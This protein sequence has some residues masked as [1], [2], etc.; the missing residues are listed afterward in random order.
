MLELESTGFVFR[1][2]DSILVAVNRLGT[3]VGTFTLTGDELNVATAVGI[4]GRV[5][6]DIT[7][8]ATWGW[9]DLIAANTSLVVTFTK[10]S[11]GSAPTIGIDRLGF[12]VTSVASPSRS[13]SVYWSDLNDSVVNVTP[14]S[15]SPLEVLLRSLAHPITAIA[16]D[17]INNKVY[18]SY[19]V[20]SNSG[21]IVRCD[22]D[23]TNLTTILTDSKN[24]T[25]LDI[26]PNGGYVYWANVAAIKR[27]LVS[28][29][30]TPTIVTLPA[31][32]SSA[33][34]VALDVVGGKVYWIQANG[35]K[36]VIQYSNLD[37]SSMATLVND[38]FGFGSGN[39]NPQDIELDLTA[40]KMYFT[41]ARGSGT[42]F[43]GVVNLDGTNPQ[44]LFSA[45][46]D[47]PTGLGL[48]VANGIL[49]WADNTGFWKGTTAGTNK[50]KMFGLTT[51]HEV[52]VPNFSVDTV[53]T[54]DGIRSLDPVPLTDTYDS[55]KLQFVSASIA[56]DSNVGGVLTWNNIG[57]INAQMSK[58]ITV[59]FKAVQLAGNATA[60]NVSNTAAVTAAKVADGDPA[61]TATST[62]LVDITATAKI[63]DF[64]WDDK[65]G[66]GTFNTGD[67][68]LPGVGVQLWNSTG[69]TM[70]QS[71]TTDASGSYLFNAVAGTYIV[72][73]DTTTL[74]TGY[75]ATY[76]ADGTGTANQSTVT[77]A[78]AANP[79]DNLN[80]DVG[81]RF[82][83]A[84]V[85]G[86]VWKD[87]NADG[88]RA[89]TDSGLG[90]VTVELRNSGGTVVYTTTTASDG[91]YWFRG[92]TAGSYYL[93]VLPATLP[94]GVGTWT[95]TADPD[96]T[97]D[98]RT[99]SPSGTFALVAGDIKGAYDFGYALAGT[100]SIG[101]QVFYDWNR[102]NVMDPGDEGIPNVTVNLY[103]DVNYN[104]VYDVG[105]DPLVQTTSTNSGGIYGFSNLPAGRFFVQVDQTDPDFLANVSP[106]TTNPA[107]ILLYAGEVRTDADFGYCP[108]G[109]GS[110]SGIVWHD[111]NMDQA[112]GGAAT[113]E[114]GLAGITVS[115]QVDLNNDGTWVTLQTATTDSGGNYSFSSL[116]LLTYRVVVSPTDP[117]LPK[118]S[119][120]T[121]WEN[122]T[123]TTLTRT[124]TSGSPTATANFGFANWPAIGDFV[125]YDVNANGTQDANETGIPNVTL[126]LYTDPNGDGTGGALVATTTTSAGGANP[127]GFYQFTHVPPNLKYRVVVDTTTLPTKNGSPIP[128]TSDPNRD[129]VPP[130]WT[131]GTPPFDNMDTN[132]QLGVADYN[133]ADFG[134]QPPGSIGDRVW[135]DQNGNGVQDSGEPGIAG[136][137]VTAT[138]GATTYTT[139]T[140]ADG[141]YSFGNLADGTWTVWISGTP[142]SGLTPTY[143]ADGGVL[144][145]TSV[146]INLGD[147]TNTFGAMGVDFGLM[148]SGSYS[149]SGTVVSNDAPVLGLV[150]VPA[151]EMP[152]LGET[153]YLYTQSGTFLGSTT[154]NIAGQYSF[155]HLPNGTYKV[156]L[157]TGSRP[158]EWAILDTVTGQTPAGSVLDNGSSV[159]QSNIPIAGASVTRVDFAFQRSASLD[160]GDLP[161]SYG[162]TTFNENG[163]WHIIPSGGA[164]VYLGTVKPDADPD[165]RPSLLANGDDITG[166]ADEDGVVPVNITAWADGSNG[167]SVRVTVNIPNGQTAYLMGWIDFDHDNS[168]FTP[169]DFVI[170]QSITGTGSAQTLTIPFTI[171]TGAIWATDDAWYARFRIFATQPPVPVFAF[172]GQATD[173]EVE[174]Y[175]F[176]RHLASGIGDTVW[177]D[178]NNNGVQDNGEVGLGGV[179]VTLKDSGGATL[180]TEVTSNG[181]QD[182]NGDGAVDPVGYYHF[183]GLSAGN[184]TVSIALPGGYV[185]GY[186]EN[187]GNDGTTAVTLTTTTEHM[188]AD[189]GLVVP[190]TIGDFVWNDANGN[191]IQDSG[192]LGLPGV[193]VNLYNSGNVL[194]STTTTNGSGGYSFSVLPGSYYIQLAAPSGKA[195]SPANQGG[196]AA[197]DSNIVPA[198]GRSNTVT[199]TK[200]QTDNTIDAGLYPLGTVGDFVWADTNGNGVQDGGEP[201]LNSVTVQLYTSTGTLVGTTTTN[202]SGAY[203]FANVAQGTYYVQ[204]TAPGG[205]SFTTANQGSGTNDSR[206]DGTGKTA[207]FTVAAGQTVSNEDAGLFQPVTVG[208][209]VWTDTNGNGIQDS[210]E[211]G[212]PGVTVNLYNSGNALVA[213]GRRRTRAR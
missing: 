55:T 182:V 156:V 165:G 148:L 120:G 172:L 108:V 133:G 112:V 12:N 35:N 151:S 147:V 191:G 204:F 180:A 126:R 34:G 63:G 159:L 27:A 60:T 141:M 75:T 76:D 26:D 183:G 93:D 81:Y 134:Y 87:F 178:A 175:L 129:G 176:L 83:T 16:F 107:N 169:G 84:M 197:K 8:M 118:D 104:G 199:L 23:G 11:G 72:K 101:D 128:E 64:V 155:T 80:Q 2:S 122:T 207:N 79:A 109:T 18:L 37:G 213:R 161:A 179:T 45:I 28:G 185:Y 110:L 102:N 38:S 111:V 187:G 43:M 157:D 70:L 31:T 177:V 68:A 171:P 54:F 3:Q 99:P 115:L 95:Q 167:G 160:Y 135:L 203:S 144:T 30:P 152:L 205:Y 209:F 94:T 51:G 98:S 6:V 40:G 146:T 140:D 119:S 202:G 124:L 92:V 89:A 53:G 74:S 154:T 77:I 17:N 201:G 86:N 121:T 47:A 4:T 32:V 96:A 189:F 90:S 14:S 25:G 82:T 212:L 36:V 186:D 188:T 91:T 130:P 49:Y 210:G 127:A 153:V 190:V 50:Q 166:T 158:V 46:G 208:D 15:G 42:S 24:I 85:Y 19:D 163:A 170:N 33:Q 39:S 59:T 194:V 206:P 184:Y 67:V 73:I 7:D 97:K 168:F 113:G 48:D 116:P 78:T 138:K 57:P 22:P 173:G 132:I 164:T 41:N 20:G 196:D 9:A 52:E 198:T 13:G 71:T 131:A 29:A 5:A 193:P 195:F 58:T 174:D 125:F 117:N 181:S 10:G 139:T 61:N 142:L 21:V 69:T 44:V 145:S 150:D 137:T 211:L 105:V 106:S 62:A 56:P 1:S 66:S 149:L 200:G 100:G 143:D 162:I 136:V 123:G 65:D 103:Q 192:E 114:T 88:T